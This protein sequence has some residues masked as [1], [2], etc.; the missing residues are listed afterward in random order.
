[1]NLQE[2]SLAQVLMFSIYRLTR[3][4]T[5][6]TVS[7]FLKRRK[8][9]KILNIFIPRS[10]TGNEELSRTL[11]WV[12]VTDYKNMDNIVLVNLFVLTTPLLC[13]NKRIL[14]HIHKILVTPAWDHIY[15]HESSKSI[16]NPLTRACHNYKYLLTPKIKEQVFVTSLNNHHRDDMPSRS[17]LVYFIIMYRKTRRAKSHLAGDNKRPLE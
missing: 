1:M 2:R 7:L 8:D 15:L 17:E 12:Q 6:I 4:N 14:N 5:P 9:I 16:W 10:F 11:S 3:L 13:L